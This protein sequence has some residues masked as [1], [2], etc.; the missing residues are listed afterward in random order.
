MNLAVFDPKPILIGSVLV[1]PLVLVFS[2]EILAMV[3]AALLGGLLV[4]TFRGA[5]RRKVV[6]TTVVAMFVTI[7]YI[8]VKINFW[9]FTT[10]QPF[11]ESLGLGMGAVGI[12]LLALAFFLA[13][14][15]LGS[16]YLTRTL[17]N[18]KERKDPLLVLEG[19]CDL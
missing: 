13:P 19:R 18:L 3:V 17:R 14:L 5:M 10:N 11:V 12:Y 2:N 8:S 9:L 15:S 16:W 1:I 6:L 4:Y 7:G